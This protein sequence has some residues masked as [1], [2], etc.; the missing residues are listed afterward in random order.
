MQKWA[1]ACK[2]SKCH[3]KNLKTLVN[4]WFTSKVILFKE[5]LEFKDAINLYYLRQ[6]IAL[7]S[8]IPIPQTWVVAQKVSKIMALVVTQCV[9]N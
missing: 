5:T 6:T 7:H 1:K 2:N 4:T 3:L 9:L 8:K